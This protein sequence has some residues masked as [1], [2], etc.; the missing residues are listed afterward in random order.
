[1]EETLDP[2]ACPVC[3]CFRVA[4]EDG[5]LV[6]RNCPPEEKRESFAER[7]YKQGSHDKS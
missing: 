4:D 6:C 2:R 3:G 7:F 5:L 1:L